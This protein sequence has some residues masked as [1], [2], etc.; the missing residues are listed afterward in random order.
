MDEEIVSLWGRAKDTV[1]II[2]RII[3]VLSGLG[4][5]FC[6]LAA[7]ESAF[8]SEKESSDYY[9]SLIEP[10][11]YLKWRQIGREY[12][13]YEAWYY[14]WKYLDHFRTLADEL[15]NEHEDK[16]SKAV[17]SNFAVR[18]DLE[19]DREIMRD[20]A[21][22]Q[23]IQDKLKR[24]MDPN[25]RFKDTMAWMGGMFSLFLITYVLGKTIIFLR[26]RQ[27]S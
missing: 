15:C 26:N 21:R 1:L 13:V 2:L 6:G 9:D 19:R 27:F 22:L 5:L 20:Y 10:D 25:N 16:I 3:L 4:G 7:W 12:G 23:M 18:V 8:V 14:K 11:V 17:S 24:K